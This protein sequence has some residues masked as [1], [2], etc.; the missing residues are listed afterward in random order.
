LLSVSRRKALNLL[1]DKYTVFVI[2]V[3]VKTICNAH[4]VNIKS[5]AQTSYLTATAVYNARYLELY[6]Y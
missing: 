3:I 4:K 2:F 5:E 1:N 6:I